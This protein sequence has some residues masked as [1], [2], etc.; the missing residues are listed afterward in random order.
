MKTVIGS[1][2]ILTGFAVGIYCGLWWAFIGGIVAIIEQVKAPEVDAMAVAIGIARILFASAI[3]A[4]SA[5]VCVVPGL[6]I[7]KTSCM[8]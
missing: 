1:L 6:A 8:D 7:L 5:M 3:G 4:F 2:L